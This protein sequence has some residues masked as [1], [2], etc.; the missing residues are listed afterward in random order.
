MEIDPKATPVGSHIRLRGVRGIA[1]TRIYFYTNLPYGDFFGVVGL[2]VSNISRESNEVSPRDPDFT[3]VCD[4]VFEEAGVRHMEDIVLVSGG[5]EGG[6]LTVRLTGG[7]AVRGTAGPS[8]D[9]QGAPLT[10]DVLLQQDLAHT[11]PAV[12]VLAAA[13]T[14]HGVVV[15]A[16]GG[17]EFLNY[18]AVKS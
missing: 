1:T 11:G 13:L 5:R 2:P 8:G 3:L 6:D 15:T 12:R 18:S 7:R 9:V 16:A 10:A 17:S 14:A 4:G